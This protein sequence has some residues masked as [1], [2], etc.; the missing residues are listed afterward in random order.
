MNADRTPYFAA[1]CIHSQYTYG[2]VMLSFPQAL[3]HELSSVSETALL[4]VA[5]VCFLG[6]HFGIVKQLCFVVLPKLSIL[7]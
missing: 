4:K 3:V 2:A 7:S 6:V 1:K 5:V